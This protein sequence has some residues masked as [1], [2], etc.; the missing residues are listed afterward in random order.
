MLNLAGSGLSTASS[1]NRL[2]FRRLVSI[3][4]VLLG[5]LYKKPRPDRCLVVPGLA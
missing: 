4:F 5:N 1:F 3:R 2:V